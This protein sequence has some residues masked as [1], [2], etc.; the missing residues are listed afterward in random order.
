MC[1]V[2]SDATIVRDKKAFALPSEHAE[3]LDHAELPDLAPASDSSSGSSG[4]LKVSWR[5]AKPPLRASS[6]A[7]THARTTAPKPLFSL[8]TVR[9]VNCVH[10]HAKAHQAIVA[11]PST[12]STPRSS[13]KQ[14]TSSEMSKKKV[15]FGNLEVRN[16][17]IILG[18]H[19]DCSAGP[20]VSC[21]RL[22]SVGGLVLAGRESDTRI[23]YCTP[24]GRIDSLHSQI[25]F[26]F[27]R[28]PSDGGIHLPRLF[29]LINM[30]N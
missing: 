16:Y 2:E 18:D 17:E 24:H 25:I 30:K 14:S 19:P 15:H 22:L 23:V 10:A 4:E 13:L 1:V 20:P 21:Y 11:E 5:N 26:H 6:H 27:F 12:F 9:A 28:L 3:M 7:V 29:L 8:K